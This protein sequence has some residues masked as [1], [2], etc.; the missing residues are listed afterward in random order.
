LNLQKQSNVIQLV[1]RLHADI[2]NVSIY[3]LLG[4]CVNVRL[5]KSRRTFYLMVKDADSKVTFKLQDA[6]LLVKYV[7]TIPAVLVGHNKTLHTGALAKYQLSS[8]EV[9]TFTFASGS[10]S[11]YIDNTVLGTLPKRPL[12]TLVKNTDF[13]CSLESNPFNF[14]H[15][16]IRDFALYFNCTQILSEGL[17][18]DTG[19]EKTIV[20]GYRTLFEASGIRHSDARLQITHDMFIAEYFMLLFDLTPD[21]GASECHIHTLRTV[22]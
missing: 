12:F 18:I 21:R 16:N 14:R 10:Q 9:K 8:V 19:R 5:T 3:I 6:R 20:M 1:G 15:Y 17:H 11:Q 2:C 22:I 4:V 7:K 13:L